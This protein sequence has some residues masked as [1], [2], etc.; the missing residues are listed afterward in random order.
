MQEVPSTFE[1][2]FYNPENAEPCLKLLREID[3]PAIDLMNNYI[4]KAKG[5]IPLWVKI[6]KNHNPKPLMKHY[7]DT[8][9]RDILNQKINRLNLSRDASEFRKQYKRIANDKVELDIKTI[10][11]Q[12]SQEGKLAK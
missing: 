12:Y 4:G 10:L 7:K 1:E 11:S 9:Y 2:L 6:L 8:V 5:V 3:P